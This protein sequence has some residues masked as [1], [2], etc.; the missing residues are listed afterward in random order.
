[1]RRCDIDNELAL[2]FFLK[3]SLVKTTLCEQFVEWI[4]LASIVAIE[5]NPPQVRFM[6]IGRLLSGL[7]GVG[8]VVATAVPDR[9]LFGLFLSAKISP[10]PRILVESCQHV[11]VRF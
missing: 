4:P 1:M 3:C 2:L 7:I 5:C 11:P 8:C 6:Y 10:T 9:I